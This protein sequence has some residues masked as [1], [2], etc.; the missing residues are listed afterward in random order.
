MAQ[1]EVHRHNKCRRG[2][3]GIAQS[4]MELQHRPRT[5][6]WHVAIEDP[7]T[8]AVEEEADQEDQGDEHS[9]GDVLGLGIAGHG[10]TAIG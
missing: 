1:G 3:N 2:A 7:Q 6:V 4:Q 5:P 9:D 8:E 10:A